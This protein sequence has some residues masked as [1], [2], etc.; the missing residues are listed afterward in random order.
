LT[1]ANITSLDEL[2]AANLDD[3]KGIGPKARKEIEAVIGS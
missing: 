3:I 2:K 1:S